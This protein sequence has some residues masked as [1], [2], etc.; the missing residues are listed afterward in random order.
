[1]QFID[2]D[3]LNFVKRIQ[4]K[5]I[6]LFGAST[7]WDYHLS[8]LPALANDVLDRVLFVVDNNSL[9]INQ[10]CEIA[11]HVFDIKNPEVLCE[12]ED[13]AILITVRF[14]YHEAICEQLL[15]YNLSDQIECFSLQLLYGAKD[16]ADNSCVE[17][18]LAECTK[19]Q[20]PNKIHS[21]WFSGEEK[22]DNYKRCIESW[23]KFCPDFEICEWNTEN[24]D[25][26]QNLYMKQA[27]EKRKWAFVS[28]F[29]RLDV[30][31]R[32]GGIYLD[33]DVELLAPIDKLLNT[34]GFFCKQSDG[35][36]DLGSGF[37]APKGFPLIKELLDEYRD[38]T[39]IKENGEM[40][41]LPQPARLGHVFRKHGLKH[42]HDSQIMENVLALSNDFI[43]CITGD[44]NEW[45]FKGT[46]LGIHWH[47]GGWMPKGE[48]DGMSL[49]SK[50][51][52]EIE[53]KYFKKR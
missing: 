35:T 13:V 40:D 30:V 17:K 7:G 50:A 19:P 31:Y 48:R 33:M 43:T 1:M 22:P 11:G 47:N 2:C 28:D 39:F 46:E 53:E 5:K 51:K 8:V 12:C 49:D 20:I 16:G 36:L 21:F 15:S 9:K 26:E 6:V 44:P 41:L 38:L 29:A 4:D 34:S 37:G 42:G 25:V 23:H 14:R 3:Y 45:R 52:A 32:Y 27:Y 24:Y 18:Y 10:T